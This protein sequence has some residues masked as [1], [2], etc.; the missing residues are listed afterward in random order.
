MMLDPKAFKIAIPSKG[1]LQENAESVLF[2][3]GLSFRRPDRRLFATCSRTG[4]MVVYV[5]AIDVP[6]LLHEGFVDLGITGS[7]LVI[8]R[9][10]A[11]LVEHLKLGFGKCRLEVAVGTASKIKSVKQLAGKTVGTKFLNLAKDF[12]AREKVKVHLVKIEGATEGMV[13]LGMVDGIVEIVESGDS[14]RENFLGSIQ[15]LGRFEAVLVGRK[16]TRDDALRSRLIRRIEGVVVARQYAMLEY[17]VPRKS[18]DAATQI[19]P[20][21]NSPT[22]AELADPAWVSVKVMVPKKEVQDVMDRLEK[23]GATA[24]IETEVNHCRL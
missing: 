10:A 23:I 8:E 9:R 13:G 22:I 19:T 20:G 16:R 3:A 4:V 1:R 7:D 24:I 17:N 11:G 5:H 21:Y 15:E 2:A 12:F 14:L 18:L 6:V